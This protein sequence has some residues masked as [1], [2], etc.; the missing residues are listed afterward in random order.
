MINITNK[1][2]CCGC[3]ACGDVCTYNAISFEKDI[4]G[5]W[6]PIIDKTKCV[7]CGCVIAFVL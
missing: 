6:Y 3:N 7:N 5:F 2:D 1:I 4:E